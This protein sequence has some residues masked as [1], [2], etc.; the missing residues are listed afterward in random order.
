MLAKRVVNRLGRPF[1]VNPF[2]SG[3]E[4]KSRTQWCGVN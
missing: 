4:I 1:G 2:A 3:R